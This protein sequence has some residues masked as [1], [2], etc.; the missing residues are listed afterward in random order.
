MNNNP[1]QPRE[2]DPVLD[3][4]TQMP[5]FE[6]KQLISA[7]GMDYRKLRDLLA[8]RKWREA[9]LETI[10]VML[11]VGKREN[12][13]WLNTKS[14]DNFPCEDLFIIDKL[15]V[16]YS[17]G[18]FGF[19]VQKNIYQSC[20]GQQEFNPKIWDKFGEQVGWKSKKLLGMG[21]DWLFDYNTT[22]DITAPP[23]HL[24]AGLRGTMGRSGLSSL[25]SRLVDCNI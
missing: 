1:Q 16:K 4:Q 5:E 18:K 19:S 2:Y 15:W 10:R 21:G 9:D 17:H 14:V 3:N 6:D 8:E 22:F 25:L 7:V 24:P 23:G 20:G 13:G 11:V 12:K